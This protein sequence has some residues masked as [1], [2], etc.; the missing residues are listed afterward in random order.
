MGHMHTICLCD[1]GHHQNGQA[2]G[3]VSRHPHKARFEARYG[4]EDTLLGR[5]QEL[6]TLTVRK[7]IAHD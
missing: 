4:P 6:V 3:M 1:P 5:T 2:R 7:E